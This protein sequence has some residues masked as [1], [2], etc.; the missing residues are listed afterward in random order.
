MPNLSL[1]NVFNISVSQP[2]ATL[3][4]FNTSNVGV[5]SHEI[6]DPAKFTEDYKLYLE[7]TEVGVDFGTSSITY[8]M[9]VSIFSQTPNILGPG[10]YL[11]IFLSESA[12]QSV[13]FSATPVSGVFKLNFNSIPSADINWNDSS[14]IIQGKL[15]AIAGLEQAVVTGSIPAGLTVKLVKLGLQPLLTVTANTMVT[16][17]AVAVVPTVA[18]VEAGE[19]PEEAIIRTAARVEYFGVMFTSILDDSEVEDVSELIQTLQKLS[20][21]VQTDPTKVDAAGSLYNV[22]EAG[23][24]QTRCLY[25]GGTVENA[26]R[27]QAAYAGRGLSVD[28]NG[29]NTTITMHLKTLT[30]ILSDSTLSQTQLNKCQDAGVDCLATFGNL[31]KVFCAE[32]NL[33]FDRI[34]NLLWYVARA[35]IDA[36]NLYAGTP[37]KIPQTEDGVNQLSGVIRK[38]C[39]AAVTNQYCAPGEWDSPVTFGNQLDLISNIRQFGYYIFFSPLAKQSAAARRARQAP[40]GQVAL[41]EAGA[42]HSGSLIINVNA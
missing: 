26:L 6:P 7:P 22:M 24:T 17:G 23:L 35:Q 18:S 16:A 29:N 14:S 27:F 19:T 34:Y 37:T 12:V 15:R 13:S 33:F 21:I 28:F 40:L 42:Q 2:G 39:E 8:K 5:I 3:G 32:A 1:N 10:G 4:E 25:Y 41:K 9:A 38:V 31:P 11:V 36:F 30:G 20:F